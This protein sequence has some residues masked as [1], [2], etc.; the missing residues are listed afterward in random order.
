MRVPALM[1]SEEQA[2]VA[3]DPAAA[4]SQWQLL[5][6]SEDWLAV[7]LGC[8]LLALSACAVWI[9]LPSR[10]LSEHD[11]KSELQNLLKPWV[12]TP[13]SWKQNPLDGLVPLKKSTP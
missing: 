2:T 11:L 3:N 1:A 7:W 5:Y 8:L 9:P 13:K 6:R 10:G 12:A 4:P